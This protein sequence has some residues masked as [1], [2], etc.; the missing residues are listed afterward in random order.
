[1][2]FA[3]QNLPNGQTRM[4]EADGNPLGQ[5]DADRSILHVLPKLR[6]PAEIHGHPSKVFDDGLRCA[7]HVAIGGDSLE[8]IIQDWEFDYDAAHAQS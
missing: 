8:E 5:R 6:V 1:M 3:L 4:V 2:K 7:H